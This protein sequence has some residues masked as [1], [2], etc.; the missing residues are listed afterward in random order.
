MGNGLYNNFNNFFG[1]DALNIIN[2]LATETSIPFEGYKA[3][4]SIKF[5]NEDLEAIEKQFASTLDYITPR[6]SKQSLITYGN[7]SDFY[8]TR[9]VSPGHLKAENSTLMR[10]RYINSSDIINRT[11]YAV[12]G[13]MVEKDLFENGDAIGKNIDIS[14]NV[15]KVIGVFQ[16]EGGDNEE[17]FIYIPYTTRQQL[18]G[19]DEFNMIIVAYRK[20]LGFKNAMRFQEQ[21]IDFIKKRKTISPKDSRSFRVLNATQQYRITMSFSKAIQ[22]VVFFITISIIISGIIGISNIMVFVVKERTKEIGIR[23]AIGA[24]PKMIT[25][26]IMLESIFISSIFGLS[27]MILGIIILSTLQ[28]DRLSTEY[29]ILNPSI[30]GFTAIT[31]TLLLIICG[32]IAAYV[33]ARR[34]SKIKP[35]EALRDE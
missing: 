20:N 33:P 29:L 34:A 30:N 18:E 7:E 2:I 6:I 10:G 27:G 24:T 19:D 23:K 28:G 9:G 1:E 31:V 11:S 25:G 12:I 16:D 15:F 13:R 35:I 3:K 32:A 14:G 5:N 21:L 26:T 4:R 22:Y 17:R 8:S